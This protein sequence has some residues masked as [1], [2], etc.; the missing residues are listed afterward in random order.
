M[1]YKCTKKTQKI[2]IISVK[3]Y[4]DNEVLNLSTKI[5]EF[6]YFYMSGRTQLFKKVYITITG[7]PGIFFDI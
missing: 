6:I 7:S 5:G 1:H 4:E 2:L 3:K